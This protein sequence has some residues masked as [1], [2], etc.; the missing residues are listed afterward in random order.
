MELKAVKNNKVIGYYADK[1]SRILI[2]PKTFEEIN[3]RFNDL[4][5]F[6]KDYEK[7]NAYKSWGE[8]K[9]KILRKDRLRRYIT[10]MKRTYYYNPL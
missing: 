5:K 3:I 4:Y 7:N 2:C 1:E 8:I 6:I 9:D 10:R